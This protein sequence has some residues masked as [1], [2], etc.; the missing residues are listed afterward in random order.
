VG[1][2]HPATAIQVGASMGTSA[3]SQP[4]ASGETKRRVRG[5]GVGD[6]SDPAAGARSLLGAI[7]DPTLAAHIL[8]AQSHVL[9]LVASRAPLSETLTTL[10]LLVE[11]LLDDVVCT[12][13]IADYERG[14]LFILAAPHLP[15]EVVD[16]LAAGM[17]IA[18]GSAACGTAVF[19]GETVVVDDMST[20]PSFEAWRPLALAHG[21]L[22]IWS[23][24]IFGSEARPLGTFAM[25][26]H[27]RRS[28]TPADLATL[29]TF[30]AL[31]GAAIEQERAQDRLAHQALHDHLTGLPNRF[32]LLDRISHAVEQLERLNTM[33]ALLFCDLDR[34]K[35]IN[36][37]L[38]HEQGDRV[39]QVIADRL[40]GLMRPGDTAARFGGDEFVVLCEQIESQHDLLEIAS[41]VQEVLQEPIMIGGS[42]VFLTCSIGVA[43][44]ASSDS[45]AEALLRDADAA[46]YRAKTS[47]E[48]RFELFDAEMRRNAVRRLEIENALHRAIS[49]REIEVHYQPIVSLQNGTIYGLEALARWRHPQRGLLPPAEFIGIAEET[50]LI[51]QIGETVLLSACRQLRRWQAQIPRLRALT[52]WVNLSTRQLVKP[53]LVEMVKATL[54][55]TGIQPGRLCLEVT[56]TIT[57]DDT[58]GPVEVLAALDRLGLRIAIDDFGTGYSSLSYLKRLHAHYL[59]LDQSFVE[60]LGVN[61]E[62]TAIVHAIHGLAKALGL[63]VVVE[64]VERPEQVDLVRDLGSD[65]AQGWAFSP[66]Q[67]AADVTAMLAKRRFPV[68]KR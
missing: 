28:P 62:D 2:D 44:A 22:A 46:M 35:L 27:E 23:T 55:E 34:F 56:E 6:G 29:S 12:V 50:G 24:P 32:L 41:R 21:L 48:G 61:S 15:P 67:P 45:D 63:G 54:A 66:A 49:R 37:S 38:G 59:K 47:G 52:M 33:V 39:L 13:M 19:R 31:A 16:H 11:E 64:G 30:G 53:G 25:Y 26:Y 17:E 10:S 4:S 18:E 51:T 40:Q 36:D 7:R 60:G 65:L 68:A 5:P 8:A 58:G 9:E 57:M 1:L 42:E 43:V 14:L 20:H 3:A